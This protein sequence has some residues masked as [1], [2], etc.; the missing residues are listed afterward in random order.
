MIE[1]NQPYSFEVRNFRRV[2]RNR[3]IGEVF[4]IELEIDEETWG[5]L[6]SFPTDADG[7]AS[8]MWTERAESPVPKPKKEKPPKGDYGAFWQAMVQSGFMAHPDMQEV[9][10]DLRAANHRDA[11]YPAEKLIY[12]SFA[13]QSRAQIS[14]ARLRDWLKVRRLPAESSVW[15]LIDQAERKAA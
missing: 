6:G 9:F 1:Q 2:H 10:Y 3:Q 14:P 7:M 13:V 15:V 11:E 4:L 5:H 12:D 8:L